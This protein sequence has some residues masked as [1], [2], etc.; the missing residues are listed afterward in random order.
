ML[1]VILVNVVMLS[2]IMLNVVVPH[3]EVKTFHFIFVKLKK[4]E[5]TAA[6]FRCRCFHLV[7]LQTICPLGQVNVQCLEPRRVI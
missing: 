2:V 1:S 6:Y 3:G 4:N 7:S 5:N